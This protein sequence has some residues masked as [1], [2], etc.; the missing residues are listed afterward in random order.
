[1]NFCKLYFRI[2]WKYCSFV[3]CT[4][5]VAHC[6]PALSCLLILQHGIMKIDL[7]YMTNL[8]NLALASPHKHRL[9]LY[10]KSKWPVPMFDPPVSVF[11]SLHGLWPPSRPNH[12]HT[13]NTTYRFLTVPWLITAFKITESDFINTHTGCKGIL[14]Y[15]KLIKSSKNECLYKWRITCEPL[16]H[17]WRDIDERSRGESKR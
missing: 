5:K 2:Y 15:E 10:I 12:V 7:I 3:Y 13:I 14:W 17:G 11:K 9:W 1:M 4:S 8:P 16:G 6:Q